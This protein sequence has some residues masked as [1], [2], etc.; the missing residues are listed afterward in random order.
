MGMLPWQHRFLIDTAALKRAN[1][2]CHCHVECILMALVERGVPQSRIVQG[3]R[4]F[5]VAP[6]NRMNF[7]CIL[8]L[9][10]KMLTN[11]IK[12]T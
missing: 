2:V 10:S 9:T 5:L 1:C 8:D 7:P 11:Y 3:G 6:V 12:G 4:H